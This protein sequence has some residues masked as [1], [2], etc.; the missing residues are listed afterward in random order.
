MQGGQSLI[1]RLSFRAKLLLV[2]FV[3]FS[4]LIDRMMYRR[5]LRQIGEEPPARQRR[6]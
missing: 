2:L 3:P 5:Y 4:Y 1:S 6:A